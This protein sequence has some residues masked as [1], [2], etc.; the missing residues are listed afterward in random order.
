MLLVSLVDEE[1]SCN[2]VVS[3][4]RMGS[5]YV[6]LDPLEERPMKLNEETLSWCCGEG[7]K[8]LGVG[9]I[10]AIRNRNEMYVASNI[11]PRKRPRFSYEQYMLL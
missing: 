5:D 10:V 8:I 11:R 2:H 6:V 7:M 4:V 9:E 1:E 3:I